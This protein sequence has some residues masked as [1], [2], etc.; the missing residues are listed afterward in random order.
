[1]FEAER[2]SKVSLERTRSTFPS[3][4]GMGLSKQ[5]DE[6]NSNLTNLKTLDFSNTSIEP[7]T[8][9]NGVVQM[10]MDKLFPKMLKIVDNGIIGIA[11]DDTVYALDTTN[12]SY[13]SQWAYDIIKKLFSIRRGSYNKS[14]GYATSDVIDFS[15]FNTLEVQYTVGGG[16][17]SKTFDISAI[18]G[19][20]YLIISNHRGGGD[21]SYCNVYISSNKNNYGSNR[22]FVAELGTLAS[23]DSNAYMAIVNLT[24]KP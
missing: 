8:P 24:L 18:N 3:T 19:A 21:N 10:L 1:M 15:A 12:A 22:V 23:A 20:Y 14:A 2:S 11:F 17:L 4:A 6:L 16:V 9:F 7:T 5:I 13:G